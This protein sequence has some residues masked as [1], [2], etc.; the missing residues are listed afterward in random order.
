MKKILLF[1]VLIAIAATSCKKNYGDP[2]ITVAV[3][4]PTIHPI[5]LYFSVPVGT[6]VLPAPAS[7]AT[8]WDSTYSPKF[9]PCSIVLIDS[10]VHTSVPGLYQAWVTAKNH[11]GYVSYLPYYVAVTNFSAGYPNLAG[12]YRM[13]GVTSDTAD[14]TVTNLVNGFYVMNNFNGVN[15]VAYPGADSSAVF[16]A[17]TDTTIAFAGAGASVTLPYTGS[18]NDVSYP[19]SWPNSFYY[20]ATGSVTYA[21][22]DTSLIYNGF[23]YSK[24]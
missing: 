24:P 10:A 18:W 7:I 2:S 9:G 6:A 19:P 14:N 15:I 8:A 13:P 22:G 20:G 1:S 11:Y 21:T 23:T 17:I 3:S 12:T 16:A 4:F 5:Q